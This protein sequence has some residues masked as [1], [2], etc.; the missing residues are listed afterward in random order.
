MATLD[1]VR[2]SLPAS[3]WLG[4]AIIGVAV[5]VVGVY[6]PA[7]ARFAYSGALQIG[8]AA[9]GGAI[10]VVGLSFW[11]DARADERAHPPQ[12]PLR[13]HAR[14]VAI[15]PSFEVYRPGPSARPPARP[16]EPPDDEP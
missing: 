16:A 5:F 12:R 3:S 6:T 8:L 10:A 15:A 14:E 13:G 7:L 4:V 2:R 11:W 1:S 9:V